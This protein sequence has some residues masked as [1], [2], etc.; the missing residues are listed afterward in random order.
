M[1]VYFIL[2]FIV[3]ILVGSF[4]GII[5]TCI[6]VMASRDS[7]EREVTDYYDSTRNQ[8]DNNSSN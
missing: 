1:Y 4:A 6:M 2:I 7:R 5:L 8:D 3:G